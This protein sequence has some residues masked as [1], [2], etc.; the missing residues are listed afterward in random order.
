MNLV[1][2]PTNPHSPYTKRLID[3]SYNDNN[4]TNNIDDIYYTDRPFNPNPH[5]NTLKLNYSCNNLHTT[6]PINLP[7]T[8]EY[9]TEMQHRKHKF[10]QSKPPSIQTPYT[11]NRTPYNAYSLNTKINLTKHSSPHHLHN[12]K[13]GNSYDI[14]SLRDISEV[15]CIRKE[16][17]DI[18]DDT[19]FDKHNNYNYHQYKALN[20]E[21]SDYNKY[22]MDSVNSERKSNR[23]NRILQE[24]NNNLQ[25]RNLFN[26][27][28]MQAKLHASAKKKQYRDML[29]EQRR[30]LVVNKLHSENFDID[31][32]NI[33]PQ[34]YKEVELSGGC[35]SDSN[36]NRMKSPDKSFINK[37]KFVE[38]NPFS[39][40]D[41]YLGDTN[42][43][44]NTILHPRIDYKYNKYMFNTNTNRNYNNNNNN[45]KHA[46][47]SPFTAIGYSIA[48]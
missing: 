20:R 2:Y 40:K 45:L 29:D 36:S 46:K 47:S 32:V 35:A 28:E 8:E 41:Y 34:Y 22:L 27:M 26:K 14:A 23:I 11:F 4:N 25:R 33:N 48:H 5:P 42:M 13:N 44:Y 3:Y 39:K 17:T 18:T 9:L 24:G 7:N 38:V 19:I 16:P 37:N 10:F 43:D 6:N 1:K 21:Y 12:A 31:S 30:V 15:Y